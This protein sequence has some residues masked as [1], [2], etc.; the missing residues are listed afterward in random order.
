MILIPDYQLSPVTST[1]VIGSTVSSVCDDSTTN[2]VLAV[3]GSLVS[4]PHRPAHLADG[5]GLFEIWTCPLTANDTLTLYIDQRGAIKA[6]PSRSI[7]SRSVVDMDIYEDHVIVRHEGSDPITIADLNDYDNDQDGDIPFTADTSGTASVTIPTDTKLLVWTDK[8]FAPNGNVILEGDGTDAIDGTVELRDDATFTAVGGETHQVGGDLTLGSGATWEAATS[9]LT[10]TAANAGRTIAINESTLHDVTFS[11]SGSWSVTDS[12][13]TTTGD[14][15]I[16][17]GAVTL[18]SGTST[19][20]S[21]FTN[22]GGSFVNNGGTLVFTAD[23]SGNDVTF[24]GSDAAAVQFTGTGDWTFGDTNATTTG[25]VTV[26]TGTVTLPSGV[27]AVGGDFIVSD[28]IT[29]NGGTLALTASGTPT[30][31]T[32]SSNDLGSLTLVGSSTVTM[33]DLSAALSGDLTINAGT[34]TNGE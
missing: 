22:S 8:E 21:D 15:L 3:D 34:L 25:S 16:S 7:R 2:I 19:I 10:F 23:D 24:G 29:E 1:R 5:S 20:G 13:L 4:R 33:T 28:T 31:L 12:T 26:A 27:L 30:T 14:V 17:N 6:L 18:P 9:T 32:L 11:G